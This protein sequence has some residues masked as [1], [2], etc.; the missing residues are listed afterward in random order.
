LQDAFLELEKLGLHNEIRTFHC[1]YKLMH[2]QDSP[3]LS[4]H[5][6]GAAIDLNAEDNPR[7]TTGAWSD[8][9]ILVM[10][11]YGIHCGQRWVGNSE[12]MHFAMVDGE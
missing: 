10:E 6:W 8:E 1:S 11:K 9:L 5:S 12:P 3:V 7:G 2:L 4:V